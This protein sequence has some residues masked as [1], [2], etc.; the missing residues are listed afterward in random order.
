MFLKKAEDS[1]AEYKTWHRKYSKMYFDNDVPDKWK[2][3][4]DAAMVG[5]IEY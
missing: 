1:L 4:V 3:I 2:R 5:D